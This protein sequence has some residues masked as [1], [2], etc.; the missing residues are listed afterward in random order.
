MAEI[1]GL[2]RDGVDYSA[3]FDELVRP[4]I[5][6]EFGDRF[7]EDIGAWMAS[8]VLE[9]RRLIGDP[10]LERHRGGVFFW[11]GKEPAPID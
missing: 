7:E 4:Q 10:D 6:E 8:E 9:Y 3:V 1:G 11:G 2:F 5:P